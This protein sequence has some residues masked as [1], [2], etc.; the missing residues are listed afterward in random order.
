MVLLWVVCTNS[1]IQFMSS[2]ILTSEDFLP[3]F[4]LR[5]KSR[6]IISLLDIFPPTEYFLF[7][8][9]PAENGREL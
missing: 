8:S 5:R 2:I 9:L 4:I 6:E 3:C 1:E 7:M